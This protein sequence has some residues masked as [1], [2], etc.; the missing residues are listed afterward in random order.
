[1]GYPTHCRIDSQYVDESG[2]PNLEQIYRLIIAEDPMTDMQ[3][4]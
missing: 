3:D 2:S 4:A 1:M